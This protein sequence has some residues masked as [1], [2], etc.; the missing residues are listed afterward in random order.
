M[1]FIQPKYI[2][3]LLKAAENRKKEME[4]RMERKIHKEREAEKGKFDDRDA[5]VTESYRQKIEQMRKDEEL[6]KLNEEREGLYVN[7]LNLVACL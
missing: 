6:E 7:I 4:R 1:F 3:N 5:F 2:G